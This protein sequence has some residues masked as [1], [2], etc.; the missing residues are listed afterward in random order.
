MGLALAAN[1]RNWTQ[2]TFAGPGH[3]H[4]V[5]AVDV[6]GTA[7]KGAVISGA[8]TTG[9]AI[10][11]AAI[12]GD[13]GISR[14]ARIPTGADEGPEA[15]LGRIAGFC[16]RLADEAAAAGTPPAA[17]GIAVPGVVDESAGVARNAVNIGWRDAPVRDLL[18]RQL[19]MPVALVHDVRAAGAAEGALGAARGQRDFLLLQIGTGIAGALVLQGRPYAGAHALGGELGHV[20]IE[21]GG[22]RCA[23]GS[24]GCLET[25]ASAAAIARRYAE[26]TG[27]GETDAAE[28]LRRA[29]ADP[30]AAQV[31]DEA[32]QA[33]ATVLAVYQN[34]LDPDLVVIGGGLAGA[35]DALLTPLGRALSGRLTFQ[36]LPRLAVSPLGG[37]AG[38]LGAA[39][40]AT[41]L[42]GGASRA[43]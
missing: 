16:A 5:V 15:V 7:I 25:I 26:R 19:D 11:G 12:S 33:L 35:G 27:D 24:R 1:G 22:V 6:G 18:Q 39:M 8:A 4:C 2:M 29:G 3:R 43:G 17:L 31:W 9:A 41:S 30:V 23:C 36:R 20:V 34:M 10:S 32:V 40:A 13:G 21:A 38:C 28:V 14:R 42:L 37:D